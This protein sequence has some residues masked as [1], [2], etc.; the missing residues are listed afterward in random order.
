MIKAYLRIFLHHV[1]RPYFFAFQVFAKRLNF[2]DKEFYALFP[3]R[4]QAKTAEDF[5]SK[6]NT[7][8]RPKFF[9]NP[10]NCKDFFL[11]LLSKV[12]PPHIPQ[13]QA[14]A[15][16][17]D[18]F[19]LYGE[20]RPFH[21][22]IDWQKDYLNDKS[23]YETPP[24]PQD[25]PYSIRIKIPKNGSDVRV[26][27]ELSRLSFSFT[28]GKGFWLTGRKEFVEK[29]FNLVQD[30]EN[31]NPLGRGAN[32][33]NA[34][35]A[36]IRSVSLISG[37]YFFMDATERHK[38]ETEFEEPIITA[39]D[40]LRLLKL[41]YNHGR[42][43]ENHL[44]FTRNSGNHLIA[45]AVGL[46]F[47][48]CFFRDT[49]KGKQWIEIGRSIL[50]EEILRQHGEDGVNFEMSLA[51]HLFVTEMLLAASR[52]AEINQ[53]TFSQAFKTRLESM[54]VF[55][56]S[57]TR[58][59]GSIAAI[60]DSDDGA[61]LPFNPE[62]LPT[63]SREVLSIA[64]L[65]FSRVDL[66]K[67]AGGFTESALW[68]FG[69][70][71]WEKLRSI[72]RSKGDVQNEF[73][74]QRFMQSGFAVLCNENFHMTLDA[75][76]MGKNGWGGHGHN[77]TLSVELFY[78]PS[79]KTEQPKIA[80]PILVDRG[81]Y[82][83]TSNPEMRNAFRSG[84]AH[85]SVMID[86]REIA[87]FQGLFKITEDNTRPRIIAWETKDNF[88]KVIAEHQ[89]YFPLIHRRSI[90]L[91][92]EACLITDNIYSEKTDDEHTAEAFYHFHPMLTVEKIAPTVY[93]LS[94]RESNS[95][96]IFQTENFQ[97]EIIQEE[98]SY[99]PRYGKI[100]K[101]SMLRLKRIFKGS[102]DFRVRFE[103]A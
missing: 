75:G 43:I 51:Y 22:G 42:F 44:E 32:W 6:F 38:V 98:Y 60:G 4:W 102:L 18:K 61:L 88:Q 80:Y 78:S 101:A 93:R 9:F 31:K 12:H 50:E 84:K 11:Q 46:L 28:L 2:K 86:E 40:F 94:H 82:C 35:E 24:K 103:L 49:A 16:L 81:T 67:K 48:G 100:E 69:V 13:M 59:D 64:S 68:L 34:M 19:T 17:N 27:W 7:S 92:K 95:S 96:M 71:G 39:S 10:L 21:D 29:F 89:A 23:L 14:N 30:W 74:P 58:S 53:V 79:G 99:S 41:I 15:I 66:L 65:L 90:E 33:M 83:Y 52:L 1:L 5:I 62:K 45:N 73:H 56:S 36:A 55:L 26:V 76:Q 70:E 85:N 37:Y 20:S 72:E 91:T 8:I 63:D 87:S 47:I 57:V 77:D 3:A 97:G 54:C 25:L